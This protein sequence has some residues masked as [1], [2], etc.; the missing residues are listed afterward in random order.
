MYE[1]S[2]TTRRS[3]LRKAAATS[4]VGSFAAGGFTGSAAASK[5]TTIT[6]TGQGNNGGDGTNYL[7]KVDDK[8]GKTGD[9]TNANQDNANQDADAEKWWGHRSG[10]DCWGNTI[11]DGKVYEGNTDTFHYDGSILEIDMWGGDASFDIDNDYNS[12]RRDQMGEVV[13]WSSSSNEPWDYEFC[14]TGS[15]S[16]KC[17]LEDDEDSTTGQCA[18]GTA[19]D[20]EDQYWAYGELTY[21]GFS[22]ANRTVRLTHNYENEPRCWRGDDS[23]DNWKDKCRPDNYK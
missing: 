16:G 12:G 11:F 21:L 1:Q 2:N 17:Q 5:G 8:Y 19:F 18:D 13:M 15:V 6:V 22:N 14:M 3:V 7:I 10:E 20:K 4:I 9:D 23:Y